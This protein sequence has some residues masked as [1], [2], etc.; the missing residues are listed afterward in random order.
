[1]PIPNTTATRST[2]QH[3]P[4]PAPS[5]VPSLMDYRR[6][7]AAGFTVRDSI[8]LALMMATAR[9]LGGAS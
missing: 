6:A 2:G 3:A 7:R 5:K 4:S 8:R 1:M 9:V